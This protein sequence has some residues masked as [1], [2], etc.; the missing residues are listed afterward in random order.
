MPNFAVHQ[1]KIIDL[2]EIVLQFAAFFNG[3]I[4]NTEEIF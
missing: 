4:V 3:V 1:E 2:D